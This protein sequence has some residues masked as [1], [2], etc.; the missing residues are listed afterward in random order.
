[1]ERHRV[2]A[3]VVVAAV[4]R[5]EVQLVGA[6]ALDGVGGRLFVTS[7]VA[8]LG[9]GEDGASESYCHAKHAHNFLYSRQ[10]YS[11]SSIHEGAA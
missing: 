5:V 8:I 2:V 1:V 3:G 7:V 10:L 6:P 11:R 4:S 9:R